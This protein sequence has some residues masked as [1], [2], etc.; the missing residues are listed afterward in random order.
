MNWIRRNGG[1]QRVGEGPDRQRLGEAGHALQEEVAAGQQGDEH[2]LQHLVLADDDT[3][4]LEQDG[5]G[6]GAGIGRIERDE[7]RVRT[8]GGVGH[9]DLHVGPWARARLG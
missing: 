8:T 7:R 2:A 5:L 3:P 6:G 4:D 1:V 9:G